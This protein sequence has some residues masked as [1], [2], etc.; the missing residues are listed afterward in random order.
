M[1]RH[2]G[3]RDARLH[4]LR[5]VVIGRAAADLFEQLDAGDAG[6]I[7]VVAAPAVGVVQLAPFGDLLGRVAMLLRQRRPGAH[8]QGCDE[9]S[10]GN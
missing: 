9:T 10:G 7:V 5:D 4:Q 8:H 1:R 3:S 2:R 6:S